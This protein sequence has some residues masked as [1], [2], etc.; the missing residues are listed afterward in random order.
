VHGFPLL[1]AVAEVY[2]P[3][4]QREESNGD[5]YKNEILHAASPT[6]LPV[7]LWLNRRPQGRDLGAIRIASRSMVCEEICHLFFK[8]NEM[9]SSWV[10]VEAPDFRRNLEDGR[11]ARLSLGGITVARHKEE[12]EEHQTHTANTEKQDVH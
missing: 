10:W 9:V 12:P 6:W 7:N 4:R 3:Q 2:V 8:M 1:H 11:P 5:G